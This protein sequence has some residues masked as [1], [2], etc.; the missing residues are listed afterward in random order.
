[1]KT[2]VMVSILLGLAL[3]VHAQSEITLGLTGYFPLQ[4]PS[5]VNVVSGSGGFIGYSKTFTLKDRW[6][7]NPQLQ[8]GAGRLIMDGMFTK[9]KDKYSFDV[10]PPDYKQSVLN[11]YTL[12][13]PVLLKY[14]I[15][16]GNNEHKPSVY[17]GI[18]PYVEYLLAAQQ[19]YKIGNNTTKE[20]AP[21]QNK[22]QYG[23]ATELSIYGKEITKNLGFSLHVGT[24]VQLSDFLTDK[25]SFKPFAPYIRLGLDF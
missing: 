20:R 21:I 3:H 9:D 4:K 18:G 11:F 5:N 1:M 10:T 8:L 19:H 6:V 17:I 12:R 14:G 7:L 2:L 16:Q 25:T 24:Q 15:G 22:F 23:V 13:L